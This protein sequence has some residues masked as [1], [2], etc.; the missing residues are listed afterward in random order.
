MTAIPFDCGAKVIP[1][2]GSKSDDVSEIS[3]F[4]I[5]NRSRCISTPFF[6]VSQSHFRF[7]IRLKEKKGVGLFSQTNF[8]PKQI[9][10]KTILS[11]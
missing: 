9:N 1:F 5:P 3:E 4:C 11:K 8:Q 10:T 6:T 7:Y 2:D